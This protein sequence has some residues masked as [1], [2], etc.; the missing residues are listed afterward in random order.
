MAPPLMTTYD[1]LHD[2]GRNRTV[3]ETVMENPP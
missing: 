1:G 2:D 3:M